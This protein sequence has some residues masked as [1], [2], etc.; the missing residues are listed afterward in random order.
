MNWLTGSKTHLIGAILLV[1]DFG[2]KK[3]VTV[4]RMQYELFFVDLKTELRENY[5]LVY[6]QDEPEEDPALDE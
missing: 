6:Q 3:S 2:D 4:S 5:E 1:L